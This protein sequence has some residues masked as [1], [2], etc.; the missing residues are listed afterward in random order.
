MLESDTKEM[1]E[2]MGFSFQRFITKQDQSMD[3]YLK[4]TYLEMKKQIDLTVIDT[5][6]LCWLSKDICE[7]SKNIPSV[8]EDGVFYDMSNRVD[9]CYFVLSKLL[10]SGTNTKIIGNIDHEIYILKHLLKPQ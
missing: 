3:E 2:T 8:V 4:A 6:C 7:M 9:A 1:T 10:E 5:V